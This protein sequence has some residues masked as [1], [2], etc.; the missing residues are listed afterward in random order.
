VN[1]V[2]AFL[3]QTQIEDLGST[4]PF[5]R[6][7]PLDT[8]DRRAWPQPIQHGGC[9]LLTPRMLDIQSQGPSP[10][11]SCPRR[12]CIG[13]IPPIQAVPESTAARNMRNSD[14]C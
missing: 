14:S 4:T 6:Q 3:S 11:L 12:G 1:A 13:P 9:E 7:I 10:V 5:F 2:R 8:L